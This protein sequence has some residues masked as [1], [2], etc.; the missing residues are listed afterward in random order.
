MSLKEDSVL[1]L[2]GGVTGLISAYTCVRNQKKPILIEASNQLGGMISTLDTEWG[3]VEKAA[4]GLLNSEEVENLINDLDINVI[5]HQPH[6]KRRYLWNGKI[7][8]LPVSLFSL[9]KGLIGFFT[10][11]GSPLEGEDFFAYCQRI[12]GEEI[13]TYIIEPAMG[14]IYGS[15]LQLMDPKMIFSNI[16]WEPNK[17]LFALFRKAKKKSSH[18]KPKLKGL[19][20]F[21]GGM[22]E[23]I[24]GL[25]K[26]ILPHSQII[27][28]Q[29]YT[30]LSSLL[31]KYPQKEVRVCLPA[32]KVWDLLKEDKETS[33]YLDNLNITQLP[34]LSIFTVTRFSKEDLFPKPGFGILFPRSND[35][36]ANGVLTNSSIFSHRTKSPEVRS[37]T[38]IFAGEILGTKT[39]SELLELIEVDRKKLLSTSSSPLA[40]YPTLW[41]HAFPIYGKELYNFNQTLDILENN[42]LQ[43]G[44]HLKFYG[45]YRRGIGLRSIIDKI[46]QEHKGAFKN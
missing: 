18:K 43:K 37:E 31:L 28:G 16:E 38:W 46:A 44:I 3:L 34:H 45:N 21:Q 17:S 8:R 2:G 14:G 5:Q 25:E 19:I 9:V 26:K 15:R 12:F 1:I 39:E 36:H 29:P 11:P 24:H 33:Q 22:A 30:S 13:A 32:A 27:L 10:K 42:F 35:F 23:F 41:N 40:V 6:S 4:N 20:S 7:T